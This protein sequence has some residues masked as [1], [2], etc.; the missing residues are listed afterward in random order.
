MAHNFTPDLVWMFSQ[1]PI[2]QLLLRYLDSSDRYVMRF[3]VKGCCGVV[4]KYR[5]LRE[6]AAQGYV[7][8]LEWRYGQSS[9]TAIEV[10]EQ[11]VAY[12]GRMSTLHWII[13]KRTARKIVREFAMNAAVKGGQMHI[14]GYLYA[15]NT[16]ITVD[17]FALAIKHNQPATAKWVAET[18]KL[19]KLQNV[20]QSVVHHMDKLVSYAVLNK[21]DEMVRWLLKRGLHIRSCTARDIGCTGNKKLTAL[22]SP[23]IRCEAIFG[24]IET[25][26][27]PYA[28]W[29]WQSLSTD[30]RAGLT[31]IQ[32][33]CAG[34]LNIIQWAV[35]R[36]F[37]LG[38]DSWQLAAVNG[39]IL[40]L[41]YLNSAQ[42]KLREDKN[43]TS[44]HIAAAMAEQ[45]HITKWL[46]NMQVGKFD[47]SLYDEALHC[48]CGGIDLCNVSNYAQPTQAEKRAAVVKYLIAHGCP[49]T[50]EKCDELYLKYADKCSVLEIKILRTAGL[51]LNP[52]IVYKFKHDAMKNWL[53]KKLPELRTKT[54]ITR[55]EH[56]QST[57]REL[58]FSRPATILVNIALGC[59]AL[60]LFAFM[61]YAMG[62]TRGM[63][64]PWALIEILCTLFVGGTVGVI[65]VTVFMG[66]NGFIETEEE[67]KGKR[68]KA[69]H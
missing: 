14:I 9:L 53:V 52:A 16:P 37:E 46:L 56:K 35:E 1:Y 22:I 31:T 61:V 43:N 68:K 57:E 30:Q 29:M 7:N 33:C 12:S 42:I 36:G 66:I 28:E 32:K 21:D 24:A 18:L 11:L 10:S 51:P 44:L 58:L 50:I 39:D 69:T 15:L 3:V 4:S 47:E 48:N 27:I 59:L 65:M 45:H 49:I 41:E 8:I 20:K 64:L 17:H 63:P 55:A 67:C 34:T 54:Q 5:F 60:L 23:N 13:K 38:H 2:K 25:G 6:A 40:A 62:R 19:D 26:N